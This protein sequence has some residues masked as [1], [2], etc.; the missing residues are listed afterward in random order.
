MIEIEENTI[1][2]YQELHNECDPE[3]LLKIAKKGIFLIRPFFNYDKIKNHEYVVDI[4]LYSKQYF[5]INNERQYERLTNFLF[6]NE[7]P[8]ITSYIIIN[9]YFMEKLYNEKRINII[10]QFFEHYFP[11]NE[12]EYILNYLIKYN[13]I[14]NKFY[15]LVSSD[16]QN[17]KYD[18]FEY[19]YF[20]NK[21]NNRFTNDFNTDIFYDNLTCIMRNGFDIAMVQDCIDK[22]SKYNELVPIYS[23]VYLRFPPYFPLKVIKKYTKKI[24]KKNMLKFKFLNKNIDN[25]NYYYEDLINS[26]FTDD[27]IRQ[28]SDKESIENCDELKELEK[29]KFYPT[30]IKDYMIER[31]HNIYGDENVIKNRPYHN[32][33]SNT[34]DLS[35]LVKFNSDNKPIWDDEEEG[36]FTTNIFPKDIYP[37]SRTIL[38]DPNEVELMLQNPDYILNLNISS[39]NVALSNNELIEVMLLIIIYIISMIHNKCNN[40]IIYLLVKSIKYFLYDELIFENNKLIFCIRNNIDCKIFYEKL[41]LIP[42]EVI[43]NYFGA[44]Q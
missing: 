3:K 24:Y 32:I 19:F 29:Y 30:M 16:D 36:D 14:S 18:F 1:N 21:E 27:F 25:N 20:N 28:L 34:N 15:N 4:S 2:F 26:L 31:N 35:Y 40:F 12:K 13:L 39:I 9:K 44:R 41:T 10:N 6:T 33:R 38:R 22:L 5:F 43:K 37:F 7:I 8:F 42:N 11:M 23:F 17:I